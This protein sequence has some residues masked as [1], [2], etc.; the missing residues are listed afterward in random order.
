M[1][2]KFKREEYM[3]TYGWFRVRFDR[4]QQNYVKQKK[5]IKKGSKSESIFTYTL[6]FTYYNHNLMQK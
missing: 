6:M 4:K 2:G 5:T 3:Y 1:R